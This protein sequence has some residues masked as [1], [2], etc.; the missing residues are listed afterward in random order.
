MLPTALARR[1]LIALLVALEV[2]ACTG[3]APPSVTSPVPATQYASPTPVASTAPAMNPGDVSGDA[4]LLIG[5]AGD[6]DLHLIVASTN[7][8]VMDLPPGVPDQTWGRLL[9]AAT[10]GTS[11]V[12]RDLTVYET[13]GPRQTVAGAWRL[14][15]IGADPTPVGVSD[16]GQT[17][18]LVEQAPAT[19]GTTRFAVLRRTLDAKPRIIELKGSFA[20]DAMSH[21]GRILYVVEHLSGPP[22]G[23]YQVRAVDTATGALQHGVVVDKSGGNE[24]MAGWPIAQVRRP[25]GMV[26]TLYH[27]AEHPFIHALNSTDGWA[28][29]ID[30][31]AAGAADTAASADWGLAATVDGSS[32]VAANATLGLAVEIDLPDLAIARSRS[33]APSAAAGISLAKFG[34][35]VGGNVGRR[36]VVSPVG[37]AIFAAGPGGIVRITAS[38]LSMSGRLLEGVAVDAMAITPDGGTLY[39]LVHAGGHIVKLDAVSGKQLGQVPGSGFDRLL[40]VIPW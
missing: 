3:K 19:A 21:D 20:Y 36:L 1:P 29:C 32:L 30:L 25:D 22:D 5:R 10:D 11:T 12:V 40:A 23:H 4:G 9:T 8:R 34:H 24:P 6:P 2:I 13:G 31:P 38:D 17:I 37:S 16:N 27:G 15:V 28:L 18:V 39:A 7:E 26:F 33:F 14:P 35:E